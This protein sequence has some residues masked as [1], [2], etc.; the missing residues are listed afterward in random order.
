MESGYTEASEL[1]EPS[2]FP[3]SG[4]IAAAAEQWPTGP[5]CAVCPYKE[6]GNEFLDQEEVLVV[7]VFGGE[8]KAVRKD[9]YHA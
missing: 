8:E 2:Y 5:G 3:E 6:D 1:P 7:C 9:A 4:G